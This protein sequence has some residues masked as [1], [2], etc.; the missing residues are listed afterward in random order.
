MQKSRHLRSF[1]PQDLAVFCRYLSVLTSFVFCD[2]I[3]EIRLGFL[4]GMDGLSKVSCQ[5]IVRSHIDTLSCTLHDR[6]IHKLSRPTKIKKTHVSQL[7][8]FLQQKTLYNDFVFFF[9]LFQLWRN[10]KSLQSQN[11]QF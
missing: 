7:V 3:F 11:V 8:N 5:R 2:E 6:L 9:V 10:K 4:P 1:R